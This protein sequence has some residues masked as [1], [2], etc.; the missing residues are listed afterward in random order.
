MKQKTKY[1]TIQEIEQEINKLYVT[2]DNPKR[3]KELIEKRDYLYY[4]LINKL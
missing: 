3:L 1:P 4:G 2:K